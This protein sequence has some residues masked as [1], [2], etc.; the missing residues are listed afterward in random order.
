MQN[1]A[2]LRAYLLDRIEALCEG[3]ESVAQSQAVAALAKQ[4]NATLALEMQATRMVA[5][6]KI[7]PKAL[8]IK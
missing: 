7:A 3:R 8:P 6:Q 5:A 2:E 1:T 4:V